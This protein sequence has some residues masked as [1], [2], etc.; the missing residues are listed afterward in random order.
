[1][2]FSV[3][4][5]NAGGKRA[6][7]MPCTGED[8]QRWDIDGD[9]IKNR[10]NGQCVDLSQ[11]NSKAAIVYP[12]HGG[13]NQRWVYHDSHQLTSRQNGKCMT[14]VD[15]GSGNYEMDLLK[16]S[17]DEYGAKQQWKASDLPDN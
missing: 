3:Y 17:D 5:D 16:C 8:R 1:M 6:T 14:L 9:L 10:Q 15:K 7:I 13:P 4:D 2:D 11:K 12:C